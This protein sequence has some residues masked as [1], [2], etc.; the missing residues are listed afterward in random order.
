MG[1]PG[2]SEAQNPPAIQETRVQSLGHEDPPEEDMETHS[3]IFAWES[4]RTEEPGRLQFTGT[5]RAR[6]DLWLNNNI[7]A[8]RWWQQREI[9]LENDWEN[10]CWWILCGVWT[11]TGCMVPINLA[12]SYIGEI[13]LKAEGI[14]EGNDNPL[15]YSCLENPMDGGVW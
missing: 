3:S 11:L 6:H 8:R 5:Q 7:Y 15:Q 13:Y 2:G 9:N 10:D 12:D 14:G 4:P 1:F